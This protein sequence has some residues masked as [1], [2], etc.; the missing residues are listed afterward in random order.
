LKAVMIHCSFGITTSSA[1]IAAPPSQFTTMS[2]RSMTYAIGNAT[3]DEI[4]LDMIPYL[5]Y[6]EHQ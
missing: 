1:R 2:I 6:I 5:P 4:G 3:D